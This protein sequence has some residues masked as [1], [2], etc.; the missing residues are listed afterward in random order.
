ME[1]LFEEEMKVKIK[2]KGRTVKMAHMKNFRDWKKFEEVSK[3]Y[4]ENYI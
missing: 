3:Y 2:Y 4:T 1:I